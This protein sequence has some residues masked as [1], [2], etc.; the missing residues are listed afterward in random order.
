MC[1]A[2]PPTDV[3]PRAGRAR[4][5]PICRRHRQPVGQGPGFRSLPGYDAGKKLV[6]HKRHI[7]VDT[8]GRLLMVNLTPADISDSAVAKSFSTASASAG[9]GSSTSLRTAPTTG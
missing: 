3:R 2:R 8:D 9:L 5:E 1:Q 7:R 6:G 4:G